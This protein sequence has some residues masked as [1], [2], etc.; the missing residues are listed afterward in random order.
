MGPCTYL[1]GLPTPRENLT[2]AWTGLSLSKASVTL[3]GKH[4]F[5]T[6]TNHWHD[7]DLPL[8]FPS[9]RTHLENLQK[10]WANIM[11]GV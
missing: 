4:K 5:T 11:L 1:T 6:T 3:F 10:S 8:T 9:I 2:Q 7:R